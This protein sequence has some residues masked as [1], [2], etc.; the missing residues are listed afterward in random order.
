MEQKMEL[1]GL[2]ASVVIHIFKKAEVNGRDV[3]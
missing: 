1:L 3:Q 2:V